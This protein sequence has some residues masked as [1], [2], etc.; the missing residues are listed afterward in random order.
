MDAKIRDDSDLSQVANMPERGRGFGVN[1]LAVRVKCSLGS[2]GVDREGRPTNI[3]L[4]NHRVQK[5]L[6]SLWLL[7]S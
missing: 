1:S 4:E 6:F 2:G 3:F 7:A 5:S